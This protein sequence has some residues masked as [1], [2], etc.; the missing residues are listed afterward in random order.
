MIRRYT[1][2]IVSLLHHYCITIAS[3]LHNYCI[4]IVSLSYH[5]CITIVSLLHHYCITIEMC[6]I[7]VDVCYK[8]A[9]I[10]VSILL[11]LNMSLINI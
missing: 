8:S 9:V 3:L 7:Y 4:T 1:D 2:T 6:S 11:T 10:N 5:Y